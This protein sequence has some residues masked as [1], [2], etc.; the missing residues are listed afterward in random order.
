MIVQRWRVRD[1]IYTRSEMAE[2]GEYN[3]L[4]CEFLL[5]FIT[6]NVSSITDIFLNNSL[7]NMQK[8][9]I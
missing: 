9:S 6:F 1:T 4:Q 5:P 2:K 8:T 3:S 7:K